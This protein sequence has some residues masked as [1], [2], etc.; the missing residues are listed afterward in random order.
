MKTFL[1]LI[2][3]KSPSITTN[4]QFMNATKIQKVTLVRIKS[5]PEVTLGDLFVDDKLV[6]KTLENPWKNNQNQISCIPLGEYKCVKDDTGKFRYWRLLDVP[7]RSLIEIH[8]GNYEKDTKGCILIGN[9]HTEIKYGWKVE[10]S[11]ATLEKLKL[12]LDDE[13]II[14]IK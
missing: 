13:F 5:L 6:A 1:G 4:A 11:L 8:N 3:K 7:N 9:K 2:K 14:E 12:V 10:K